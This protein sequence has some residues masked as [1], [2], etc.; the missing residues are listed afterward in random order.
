MKK[1]EKKNKHMTLEDRIEIQECLCKG[2]TFKAIGRR[3]AKDPTTVSKEVKLHAKTHDN[4]FT[5]TTECCPK[6][7]KAPFVCN[8]R[9]RR[10]HSN[11]FF[12]RRKYVAKTAQEE[13]EAVRREAREGISLTHEEFYRNE[14]VISTAVK[15]G[16]NVY[17]AIMSHDVPV[18]KSTVY[19][20]IE[21]GYYTISKLDLPRAVKFKPRSKEKQTYIPKGI[22]IG[23]SY[24]DFQ[25]F[26]EQHPGTNH[27]EMDTLIG[28][29]GGKVIM[30]LPKRYG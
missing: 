4:G 22:R 10:N 13:Y 7:L 5:K 14:Q 12:P 16:Q 28:R 15:A 6:L 27:V 17:H 25:R 11:C 29:P 30:T 24:E 20:H 19:R 21:K 1:Q 18:S 2:M 9:E 8:G 23:R 3:I 26:M